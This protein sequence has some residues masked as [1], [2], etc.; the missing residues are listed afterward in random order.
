MFMKY[1]V[2]INKRVKNMR[3]VAIVKKLHDNET[4]LTKFLMRILE[5][6]KEAQLES[7]K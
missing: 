6:R 2:V 7:G 3:V 5:R 1:A 4:F